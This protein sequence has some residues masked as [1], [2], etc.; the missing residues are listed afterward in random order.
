MAKK[1]EATEEIVDSVVEETKEAEP[2]P[3]TEDL[4]AQL[5]VAKAEAEQNLNLYKEQIQKKE[6]SFARR[7]QELD[8][9]AETLNTIYPRLDG[10]EE[11]QAMQADYL[12]EMRGVQGIEERPQTRRSHLDE[13]RQ[14]REEAKKQ[15]DTQSTVKETKSEVDPED[16]RASVLAQAI[17]EEMGWDKEHPV[18]KKVWN[19]E[20]SKKVLVHFRKEQKTQRDKEADET[21]QAKLKEA[22]VT[23]SETAG[24]SGSSRSF[25]E[26]EQR[27]ADGLI[28]TAEYSKALKE[29]K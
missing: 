10:I 15:V 3:S 12:E 17:M 21:V 6:S 14:R 25:A 4:Q 20:D 29:R 2:Q 23:T 11:F 22:G 24:P 19:E 8:Q 9:R 7:E 16:L 27:Y 18:V 1:T 28:S 5:D 13:L 26:I